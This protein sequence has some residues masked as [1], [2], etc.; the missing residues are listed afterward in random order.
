M[1][2]WS[3][4]VPLLCCVASVAAA[5][6]RP[7]ASAPIRRI[8]NAAPTAWTDTNGWRLV[9]ER[10]IRP[11]DSGPSMF[12]NPQDIALLPDGRVLVLDE[13]PDRVLL[14]DA[15]GAFIRQI[16]REGDG[17]GEYRNPV[18][19][20]RA[21]T[22]VLFSGARGRATLLTLDG[23]PVRDFLTDTHHD[24]PPISVDTRNRLRV[25]GGRRVP[26]EP[27]VMQWVYFDLTG[28]KLD[29]IVPPVAVA[30]KIWRANIQGGIATTWVPLAPQTTTTF[31][32]D[33]AMLFAA[34]DRYEVVLTRTG[35]D[36]ALVFGR[37]GVQA[38]RVSAGYRDSLWTNLMRNPSLKDVASKND[39]PWT[40]GVLNEMTF[41]GQGNV[42][43]SSGRGKA[44]RFDVFTAD[45]RFLGAVPT[46]F[47]SFWR[48]SWQGARVAVVAEE[49]DSP[50]VRVYRIDRRGK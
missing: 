11:R 20:V 10:E 8:M 42:W 30:P 48:S 40:Y 5:Q 47:R 50:I 4:V 38:E 37:T 25:T 29:S 21:D 18:M 36:T 49:D 23:K 15:K 22:V 13:S 28:K 1:S 12:S 9:P 2:R 45:G 24:G 31:R 34:N 33:G 16:G 19:A 27:S 44:L 26:G 14:F 7:A 41:D 17:P 6:G 39:I 43:V 3:R 32:N 35:R 46:P